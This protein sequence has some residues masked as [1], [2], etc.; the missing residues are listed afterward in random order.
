V[1]IVSYS[2]GY[3]G[4]KTGTPDGFPLDDIKLKILQPLI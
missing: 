4:V 1:I 2:A 3:L